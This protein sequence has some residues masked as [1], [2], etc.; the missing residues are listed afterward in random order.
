MAAGSFRVAAGTLNGLESRVRE[1]QCG[2]GCFVLK[3]CGG[4]RGLGVEV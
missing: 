1:G 2:D 3:G 4:V